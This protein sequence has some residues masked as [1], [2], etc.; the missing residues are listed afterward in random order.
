MRNAHLI[1][2][3]S[4]LGALLLAFLRL[5]VDP[6]FKLTD[7]NT[8]LI[9]LIW[10]TNFWKMRIFAEWIDQLDLQTSSV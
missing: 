5:A 7:D 9:E 4:G 6:D 2:K 3:G 1:R 10:P 8:R